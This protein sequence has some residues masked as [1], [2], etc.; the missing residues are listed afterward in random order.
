M[1]WDYTDVSR[2]PKRDSVRFVKPVLLV[3]GQANG[4]HIE[5]SVDK[6]S[7]QIQH[8]PEI[9]LLPTGDLMVEPAG[10]DTYIEYAELC[11]GKWDNADDIIHLFKFKDENRRPQ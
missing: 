6:T 5:V 3:G 9:K 2:P 1:N 7:M 11:T 4:Q 8:I 10:E